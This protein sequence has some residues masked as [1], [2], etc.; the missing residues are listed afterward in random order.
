MESA[1]LT[2]T[3]AEWVEQIFISHS[4]RHGVASDVT[5]LPEVIITESTCEIADK[6][7]ELN[8]VKFTWQF[9]DKRPHLPAV[10]TSAEIFTE[11]FN[12]TFT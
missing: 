7:T 3:D 5:T 9:A 6:D 8:K 12:P 11:P 4:V 1:P 10:S 2:Q